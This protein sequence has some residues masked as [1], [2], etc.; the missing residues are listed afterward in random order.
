[1][2]RAADENH[3]ELLI[4]IDV[5]S[6][7]Q[8]IRFY[9]QGL[10]LRLDRTLFD[11][12]V[13]ELYG[14]AVRVMLLEKAAG[15]AIAPD[16]VQARSYDRHWTPVHLDFVVAELEPAIERAVSAGAKIEGEVETFQWG[17]Q[18]L[19]SDPFGNGFC[20]IQWL[21]EGYAA[22]ARSA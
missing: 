10:G 9:T 4:N 5:E 17:R 3:V 14:T 22:V 19:M 21:G 7:P 1:M 8:A 12:T 2:H 18:A 6:L 13:A 20:L 11:D 16:A 15:S